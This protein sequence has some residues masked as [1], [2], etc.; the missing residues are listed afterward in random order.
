MNRLLE[1][2]GV[3]NDDRLEGTWYTP[4]GD[5]VCTGT[6]ADGETPASQPEVEPDLHD[7]LA[8]E[9]T[10]SSPFGGE[11]TASGW[12]VIGRDAEQIVSIATLA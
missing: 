8:L 10:A 12:R 7:V 2:R 3:L 4:F 9:V 1:Y 6:R 11:D 5:H